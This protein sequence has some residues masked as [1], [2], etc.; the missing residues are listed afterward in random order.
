MYPCKSGAAYGILR[1]SSP[2]T[3]AYPCSP[4]SGRSSPQ[5]E[6]SPS[7]RLLG[8]TITQSS[9]SEDISGITRSFRSWNKNGAVET[10][11]SC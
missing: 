8:V 9:S 5:M 10:E 1:L 4:V 6:K 3:H 2:K 11:K 7:V